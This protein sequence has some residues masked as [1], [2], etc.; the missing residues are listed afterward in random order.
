MEF[1]T[2]VRLKFGQID[3]LKSDFRSPDWFAFENAVHLMRSVV[4]Q[5]RTAEDPLPERAE[6]VRIRV[7]KVRGREAGEEYVRT[8]STVLNV[9]PDRRGSKREGSLPPRILRTTPTSTSEKME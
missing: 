5:V 3:V 9:E 2:G 1:T 6:F 7:D 8:P 4:P